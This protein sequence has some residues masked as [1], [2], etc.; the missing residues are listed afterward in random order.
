MQRV[1]VHLSSAGGL[2]QLVTISKSHH[3]QVTSKISERLDGRTVDGAE[4]AKTRADG[5]NLQTKK[6]IWLFRVQKEHK[7]KLFGHIIPSHL[8]LWAI[9]GAIKTCARIPQPKPPYFSF[10]PGS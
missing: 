5:H 9:K 4:R 10:Y 6:D 7:C 3:G 8:L 1:L 2:K